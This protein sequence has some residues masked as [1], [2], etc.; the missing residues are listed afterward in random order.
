MNEQKESVSTC[1]RFDDVHKNKSYA[2]FYC[3]SGNFT[4][5]LVVLS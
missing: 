1:L 4:F 5:L 3:G 2:R